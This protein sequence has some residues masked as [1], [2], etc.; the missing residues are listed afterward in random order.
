MLQEQSDLDE[1]KNLVRLMDK[2]GL[3]SPLRKKIACNVRERLK[4]E[5]EEGDAELETLDIHQRCTNIRKQLGEMANSR[6]ELSMLRRAV[7]SG[8]MDMSQ[9]KMDPE[10]DERKQKKRDPK[11]RDP[12]QVQIRSRKHMQQEGV[13]QAKK[14]EQLKESLRRHLHAEGRLAAKEIWANARRKINARLGTSLSAAEL[15]AS[16]SGLVPAHL[17]QDQMGKHDFMAKSVVSS[18]TKQLGQKKQWTIPD[19]PHEASE[20]DGA[21][22]QPSTPGS[23]PGLNPRSSV[24]RPSQAPK[25]SSAP[26]SRPSQA[27]R[28]SSAPDSRRPTINASQPVLSSMSENPHRPWQRSPSQSGSPKR[29]PTSRTTA[30]SNALGDVGSTRSL[31]RASMP[32]QTSPGGLSDIA[33]H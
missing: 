11:A 4:Q 32:R 3:V 27:P 5:H 9:V 29:S 25:R 22:S 26:D 21:T 33:E 30:L 24:R 7:E 1:R 8:K 12:D 6:R 28:R 19:V 20:E 18:L 13:Q 2:E 16:S 31:R 15:R 14:K 10:G 23:T 17:K